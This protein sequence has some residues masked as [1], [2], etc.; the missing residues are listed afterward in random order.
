MNMAVLHELKRELDVAQRSLS[1]CLSIQ[2]TA[3]G[4]DHPTV[5]HTLHMLSKLYRQAGLREQAEALTRRALEIL[6]PEHPAIVIAAYENGRRQ[7]DRTFFGQISDYHWTGLRVD[8]DGFR[9]RMTL[10]GEATFNNG[11][12]NLFEVDLVRQDGT[13]KVSRT[14]SIP[15]HWRLLLS[16]PK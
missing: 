3:F 13:W 11:L 12:W 7:R 2:E 8:L 6:G 1:R 4:A 10:L 16:P 15:V 14:F 9:Q 5:G